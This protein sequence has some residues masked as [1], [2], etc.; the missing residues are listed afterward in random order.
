MP[1]AQLDLLSLADRREPGV[2]LALVALPVLVVAVQRAEGGDDHEQGLEAEIDGV[3]DGVE[4][5]VL[6]DVGPSEAGV[7]W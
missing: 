1:V 6:V 5:F 4:R 7:S 2:A 3:A